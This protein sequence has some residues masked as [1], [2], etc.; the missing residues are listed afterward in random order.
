MNLH[1]LVR[2]KKLTQSEYATLAG[3]N[4]STIS[5][6][7]AAGVLSEAGAGDWIIWN[8]ELIHHSME[9]A[10]GRKGNGP[11]DLAQERARLSARQSERLEIELDALRH[12]LWPVGAIAEMVAYAV[13]NM[14]TIMLG[15]PHRFKSIA[16][17][18]A[19]VA[20][21]QL[22]DLVRE[23]LTDFS[24]LRL[25]ERFLEQAKQ[26]FEQRHRTAEFLIERNQPNGHPG[27]RASKTATR[28]REGK[29]AQNASDVKN[30]HERMAAGS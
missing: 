1:Q 6:H 26:Y 20:V 25:P 15:L 21:N 7:L 16:P 23:A 2:K 17:S 13:S 28:N 27:K 30:D 11:L 18:V 14:R 22:D 19:P 5:K 9:V 24:Q 3:V 29:P 8:R 4:Q 10:A 12:K